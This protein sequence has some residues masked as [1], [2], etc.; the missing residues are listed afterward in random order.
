MLRLR[1]LFVT[2]GVAATAGTGTS[3]MGVLKRCARLIAHL[4]A[5]AAEV[6]LLH[7]GA[8]YRH[9]P[10]LQRVW[11]RVR[12]HGL[13]VLPTERDVAALLKSLRID[14]VVLGEGPGGGTMALVSRGARAAGVPQIAIENFYHPAQPA[15]FARDASWVRGWFLLGLPLGVPFGQIAERVVLAPPL[16]TAARSALPARSP[17]GGV[18]ILAYD[19]RALSA[20]AAVLERLPERTHACFIC[21]TRSERPLAALDRVASRCRINSV[22]SPSDGALRSY[23]EAASFVVCK[24]GFQQMMEALALGTP[25]L[26][27]SAPGGVPESWLAPAFRP[28]VHYVPGTTASWSRPL[29]A[30]AGWL[31]RRPSMPWTAAVASMPH[32]SRWAAGAFLELAR[33]CA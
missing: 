31:A 32:P 21:S 30:A 2:Y 24:S 33:A 23:I 10:L 5:D 19:P 7:F 26:A 18:T 14:V 1:L 17:A 4:P 25:V 13:P 28:F 9:D 8:L 12:S 3:M 16:L 11:P 29:A 22:I 27:C 15:V 6:H 20:G